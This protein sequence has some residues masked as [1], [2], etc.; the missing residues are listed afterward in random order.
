MDESILCSK[1]MSIYRD[2]PFIYQSRRIGSVIYF[3]L[4]KK[5]VCVWGGGGVAGGGGRG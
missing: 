1:N 5:G 3:L 2:R 4:K